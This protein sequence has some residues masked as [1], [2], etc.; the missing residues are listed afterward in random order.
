MSVRNEL[1]VALVG[2]HS[3]NKYALGPLLMIVTR[4]GL[5]SWS[6]CKVYLLHHLQKLPA[7]QLPE[8]NTIHQLL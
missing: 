4:V 6:I 1:T 3:E 7:Q 2:P 8:N 5:L